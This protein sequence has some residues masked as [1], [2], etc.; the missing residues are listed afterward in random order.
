MNQTMIPAHDSFK[1]PLLRI[2]AS[3][4]RPHGKLFC[5]DMLCAS[6]MS[7]VDLAFPMVTKF[8]I[9]RLL[10]R[11]LYRFFFALMGFMI[12]LY[13]FR[14]AC[15]HF[16]I[17]W[18]HTVGAYIEADMRRDLFNHLQQLSFSFYDTNRTGQIMSRVTTD[19]FEITE[20]AHHGP[21]DLFISILTL[22]GSFVLIFLFRW[23][24]ALVLVI[25]VPLLLYHTIRSRR[26]MMSASKKVKER[27]AEINASLESSISGARVAKAFTNESYEKTKFRGGNERFKSAKKSYYKTMAVFQSRLEFILH[28][29]NVIVI[30]AG[31]FLIMKG[32]MTLTELITCNLFA[33]AF[34]SPIR[35]LANFVEQFT[36]GRAGFM[37]NFMPPSSG[38]SPAASHRWPVLSF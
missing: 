9:E 24:M 13:L 30:A 20:L 21:E 38:I 23:E 16:V 28:F 31:G 32:R 35:R 33:A 27:T 3:Y 18:G 22:A 17:Y 15:N 34:L 2:F 8:T 12:L 11:G 14:M 6:L 1:R 36:T 19:L 25:V 37:R 26:K 5:A 7:A 10:P 4:Y 29:L